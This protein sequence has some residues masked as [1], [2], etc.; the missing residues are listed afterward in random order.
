MHII[1]EATGVMTCRVAVHSPTVESVKCA[2][3]IFVASE[4]SVWV[5]ISNQSNQSTRSSQILSAIP[6]HP[7]QI[8]HKP[9]SSHTILEHL[10][11][12]RQMWYDH[13]S[14]S[15]SCDPVGYPFYACAAW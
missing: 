13:F 11:Q 12:V 3:T 15:A 10:Q 6:R 9:G 14:L 4:T 7:T 5:V 1:V 2:Y 8:Q